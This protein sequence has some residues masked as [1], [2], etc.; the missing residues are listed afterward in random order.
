M[1]KM[2][3]DSKKASKKWIWILLAV[4][5]VILAAAV[6]IFMKGRT[7]KEVFSVDGQPVYREEVACIV[8]KI[9]L[10]QREK[11]AEK[12][13]I[14]CVRIYLGDRGQDGKTDMNTWLCSGGGT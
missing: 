1:G 5:A 12:A 3:K 6:V 9:K 7:E 4:I 10:Y 14:E 13:G 11:T 2:Q 8:N